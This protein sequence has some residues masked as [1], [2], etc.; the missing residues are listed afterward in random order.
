MGLG[1]L[2]AQVCNEN[3]RMV[4]KA[5]QTKYLSE[6]K[7]TMN[8]RKKLVFVKI[9]VLEKSLIKNIKHI[10]VRKEKA[11]GCQMNAVGKTTI[12]KLWKEGV[13]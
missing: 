8:E 3:F 4:Q 13:L 11:H 6:M 1:N 5:I 10:F 9:N 12:L 2:R 7:V